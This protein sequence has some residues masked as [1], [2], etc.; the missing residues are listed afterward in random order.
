MLPPQEM[1]ELMG[2]ITGEVLINLLLIW[3]TA[4]MGVAV[5]LG[6]QVLG[7]MKSGRGRD[8]LELLA[9]KLVMPRLESH[10]EVVKP[11]LLSSAATPIKTV[12]VAPLK[13]GDQ[14]V[15]NPVPAVRSKTQRTAL[16]RQEH[17]DDVPAAAK[18]P[19]GDAAAPAAS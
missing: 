4:G 18:N 2:Q 7:H 15:S 1:N 13:A 10:A 9:K 16:V 14:L 5:R 8:L 17:V 3:A 6:T 12:P 19:Q 11:L